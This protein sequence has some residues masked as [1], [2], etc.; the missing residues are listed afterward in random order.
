MFFGEGGW[1]PTK[2]F[3]LLKRA[4]E[5][6]ALNQMGC[7]WTSYDS[8]FH[9]KWCGKK[10]WYVE[11]VR[12]PKSF[13]NYPKIIIIR[14]THL[15]LS[16]GFGTFDYFEDSVD[17][18]SLGEG[19]WLPSNLL[20]LKKGTRTFSFQLNGLPLYFLWQLFPQKMAWWE[21]NCMSKWLGLP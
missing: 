5:F 18:M 7:L 13:E 6:S 3:W 9:R 17:L 21:K 11:V 15:S 14:P 2:H 16:K 19:G 12:P 8:S 20:T 4:M 1:L 10:K